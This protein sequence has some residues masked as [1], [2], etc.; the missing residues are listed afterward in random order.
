MGKHQVSVGEA[1]HT[2]TA[3]RKERVGQGS[4]GLGVTGIR[5]VSQGSYRPDPAG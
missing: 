5:T 2:G 3:L 1:G 4:A